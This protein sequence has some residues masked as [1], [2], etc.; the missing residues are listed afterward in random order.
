MALQKFLNNFDSQFIVAV[1]SAPT[2]GTPATELDYGILR[3]PTGAAATL[4]T[5]TGGDYYLLTAYKKSGSVVSN[6]EIMKVT[7]IDTG[8]IN[9]TRITVQRAQEGT[10]AQDYVPGDY[11]SLYMTKGGAENFLQ[12]GTPAGG[13]TSTNVT[14]WNA[15]YGW[16]NHASAGYLTAALAASTYQTQAAMSS[17]LLSATA[18]STYQTQAGMSSYLTTASAAS[19]YAVK[20]NPQTSGMIQ[21]SG[22]RAYFGGNNEAYSIGVAYNGTR[23][24]AGEVVYFGAT[25]SNAPD[26]VV[27]N[28]AGTEI[29]RLLNGGVLAMKTGS[30][31]E[32]KTA[33]AANDINM[34]SSNYFSKTISGA[35]TL[36]VS[37]VPTAGTVASFILDLTNGGSA[38]I[39]WWTG[40]KWAGGTAP[41]LTTAGRDVLGF[42]TH[43]GGTTWTGLVL[44]KDCK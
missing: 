32:V 24:T 23:G 34:S 2:S 6:V 20:V 33:M 41:T 5:L 39:T 15:A 19:T 9:E 28:A 8:T 18:A 38:A 21:H 31:Q 35:T 42:F 1:K 22:G 29:L 36:T 13:I 26:L 40:V 43:D 44:G 30:F 11:I 7:N 12:S 14:N 17:Y 3:L 4:G 25:N 37:N 16:G 27:S 10:T